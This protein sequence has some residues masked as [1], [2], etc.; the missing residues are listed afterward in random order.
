M[1]KNSVFIC[2]MLLSRL[3]QAQAEKYIPKEIKN[4]LDSETVLSA[5]HFD[6]DILSF[7]PDYTPLKTEINRIKTLL[8]PGVMVESICLYKKPGEKKHKWTTD[9]KTSLFNGMLSLSTLAGLRYFSTSRNKT[10]L[11]YETSTVIESPFDDTPKKD[12]VFTSGSLPGKLSLYAK[13]KDLTFGENI[14]RYDFALQTDAILFGQ[15]NMT[16]MYYGPL[17]VLGKEKLQSLIAVIDA[18]DCL[19]IY[20]I[21]MANAISFPGMKNRVSRSFGARSEAILK[22]FGEKADAAYR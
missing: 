17:P 5:A 6:E 22:W 10:R 11:F 21:S 15:I 16:T 9:E 18:G 4:R 7:L 20:C 8:K 2:L 14:Y 1:K 19:I 13:Q 3:L 12:P